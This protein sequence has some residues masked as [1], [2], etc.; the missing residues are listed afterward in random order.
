[1]TTQ[2]WM[3]DT[4]DIVTASERLRALAVPLGNCSRA[5][6]DVLDVAPDLSPELGQVN[7]RISEAIAH[8]Q[9]AQA[10]LRARLDLIR[11]AS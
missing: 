10:V 2:T 11:G 6:A 1:M 4:F 7:E 3:G 5:V 9:A 8:V